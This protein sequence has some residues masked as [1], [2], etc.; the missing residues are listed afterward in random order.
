MIEKKNLHIIFLIKFGLQKK[1]QTTRYHPL[2]GIAIIIQQR[3]S[4][5]Q[6]S[7]LELENIFRHEAKFLWFR[8][9]LDKLWSPWMF[10]S[11]VARKNLTKTKFTGKNLHANQTIRSKSKKK[12]SSIFSDISY[13]YFQ[14]HKNC[15]STL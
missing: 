10:E 12:L 5:I 4:K 8:S 13:R 7:M 11:I 1:Y 15:V 14:G 3:Y 6:V 9:D 2:C